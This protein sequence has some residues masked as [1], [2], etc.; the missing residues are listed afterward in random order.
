MK[1]SLRQAV[2]III[3]WTEGTKAYRDMRWSNSWVY[4]VDVTNTNPD[5]IKS[6]LDFLRKDIGINEKRLKLQ[7]Q[8][9]DGDNREVIESYWSKVTKIPRAR[10]SKTII[11]PKGNKI[12]KSMGTCKIRY[13]D[14]PTYL[15]LQSLLENV[16]VYLGL[17]FEK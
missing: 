15:K 4:P 11:R 3:W 10:F 1:F 14:K 5:I 7:L 12:G 16:L 2:G 13:S 8:I 6:F 9:H 17:K